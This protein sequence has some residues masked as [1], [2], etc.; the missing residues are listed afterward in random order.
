MQKNRPILEI[1]IAKNP[2]QQA[3]AATKNIAF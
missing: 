3:Q 1:I 2:M